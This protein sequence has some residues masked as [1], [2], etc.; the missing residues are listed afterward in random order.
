MGIFRDNFLLVLDF[1]PHL[2]FE[3]DFLAEVV[4]QAFGYFLVDYFL[5]LLLYYSLDL[6]F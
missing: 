1:D 2:G 4:L 5:D 3:V 6:T